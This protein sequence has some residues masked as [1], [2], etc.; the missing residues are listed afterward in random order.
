MP[1]EQH[2]EKSYP[3]DVQSIFQADLG[4]TQKLGG[5]IISSASEQYRFTAR[6]PKVVLGKTLGERTEFSCEVREWRGRH[7]G[8]GRVPFGCC[9]AQTDVRRTP[10]RHPDRCHLVHR[11]LIST[12]KQRRNG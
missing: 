2:K 8:P 7:P 6:F 11:L 1:F 4:A 3:K 12:C 5:K 9:R 10:G